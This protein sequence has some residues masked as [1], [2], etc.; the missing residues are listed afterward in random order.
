M[1]RGKKQEI[2]TEQPNTSSAE[3]IRYMNQQVDSIDRLIVDLLHDVDFDEL[4]CK[5]R[6]DLVVKLMSHQARVLVLRQSCAQEKS[7]TS[8]QR[9]VAALMSKMRGE[10]QEIDDHLEGE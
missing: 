2:A 6:I 1:P 10:G 3:T 8:D 9:F 5:E 4:K 7:R